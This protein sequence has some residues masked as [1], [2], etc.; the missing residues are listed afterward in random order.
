MFPKVILELTETDDAYILDVSEDIDSSSTSA[1]VKN[2]ILTGN[3]V[4][5]GAVVGLGVGVLGSLLVGKL[6]ENQAANN[7]H[8]RI[9]RD[10]GS[11]R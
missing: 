3:A 5:D 9:K 1:P 11:A 7:C 2:R 4:V 10:G 8:Y 6:L